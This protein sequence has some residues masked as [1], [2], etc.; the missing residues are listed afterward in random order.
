MSESKIDYERAIAA[1]VQ[2]RDRYRTMTLKAIGI[3]ARALG[4]AEAE[5]RKLSANR[6]MWP[7]A[8][9]GTTANGW[10]LEWDFLEAVE[11]KAQQIGGEYAPSMEGVEAVLLAALEIYPLYAAQQ[12]VTYVYDIRRRH[13]EWSIKTFGK[14]GPVGPLKHLSK[15]AL[16]AVAA[17]DDLLEWADIQLL[18]WDAQRKAGITDEQLW[19]ACDEKLAILAT[20]TYP[21]TADGEPSFHVK[22][23]SPTGF[24]DK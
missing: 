8:S 24:E 23:A 1:L 9:E 17:P 22:D 6:V 2:E 15:E 21:V 18:L 16:E 13:A 5:I 4:I 20:R 10:T 19:Q 7:V 12:E 14:T 11:K 3:N